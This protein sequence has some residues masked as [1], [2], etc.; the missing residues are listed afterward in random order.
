VKDSVMLFLFH[1]VLAIRRAVSLD[2]IV[3]MLR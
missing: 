1:C 2:I 3:E